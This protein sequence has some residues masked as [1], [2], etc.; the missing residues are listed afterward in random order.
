LATKMMALQQPGGLV[1][2]GSWG[3]PARSLHGIASKIQPA[4]MSSYPSGM[5]HAK[6]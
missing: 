3:R 2:Q 6:L 1:V 4:T 5:D